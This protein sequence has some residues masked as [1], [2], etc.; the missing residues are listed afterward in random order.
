[1]VLRRLAACF[2]DNFVGSMFIFSVIQFT[3]ASESFA[4]TVAKIL[5]ATALYILFYFW[6]LRKKGRYLGYTLMMLKYDSKPVFSQFWK[7]FLSTQY[8]FWEFVIFL[9]C[10]AAWAFNED[11]LAPIGVFLLSVMVYEA[12]YYVSVIYKYLFD[13][14][15]IILDEWTKL[16]T[17]STYKGK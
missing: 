12:S 7:I 9:I 3:E 14:R 10:I 13:D 4:S 1:M 17:V 16:K 11:C 2:I 5:G 6:V 15:R 8:I